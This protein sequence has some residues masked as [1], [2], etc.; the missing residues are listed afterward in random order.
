MRSRVRSEIVHEIVAMRAK[1][2]KLADIAA[3]LTAS[4]APTRRGGR[5]SAEQVRSI[6]ERANTHGLPSLSATAA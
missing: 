1:G 4:N 6:V 3:Y 2:M 5:W